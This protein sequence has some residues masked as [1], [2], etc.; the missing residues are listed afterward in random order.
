MIKYFYLRISCLDNTEIKNFRD[1]CNR[2][3]FESQN[4]SHASEHGIKFLLKAGIQENI[5]K[6]CENL[7]IQRELLHKYLTRET[8]VKYNLICKK[9]SFCWN[10]ESNYSPCCYF[11]GCPNDCLSYESKLKHKIKGIA[12]GFINKS[13][14]LLKKPFI[15]FRTL[16]G[17]VQ[18]AIVIMCIIYL[19]YKILGL[20]ATKQII[21][22]V[23]D[24]I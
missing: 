16:N 14:F 12:T 22:I 21:Q 7:E 3:K 15:Y 6:N 1:F 11:D 23:K 4:I 2:T 17:W 9:D 20:E 18:L 19:L 10:N 13:I 5:L 8:Y 24:I